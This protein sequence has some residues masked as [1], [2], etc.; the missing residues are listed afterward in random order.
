VD[1]T[2]RSIA[3][4]EMIHKFPRGRDLPSIVNGEVGAT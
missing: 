4:R 3:L 2:G 1:E